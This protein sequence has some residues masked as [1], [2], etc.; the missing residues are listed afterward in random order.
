MKW[1]KVPSKFFLPL[2]ML[3]AVGL[4]S[5]SDA[6]RKHR[7]QTEE[8]S[9][10]IERQTERLRRIM[11]PLLKV[12]NQRMSLDDVR[13]TILDD[14]AINA[15]AGGGGRYFVT[16]GLLR[17]A[18]DDRLRGVLAHEIAHQDLHH[19]TKAQ[20]VGV[21]IGIGA[22]I[23]EQIFP[24]AATVAPLAGAVIGSSYTRPM[25][26]EA[27]RHAV[28]LLRRAGYSEHVMIDT[29]DWLLRQQ[30]DTGGGVMATHP[31]TSERIKAL[32]ALR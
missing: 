8:N 26:L 22:A 12:T 14:A 4:T 23:L 31:A 16:T 6:S 3:L 7:Y 21:G 28:T 32:Q 18:N 17:Q 24:S 2:A 5:P 15:G 9:N 13:I 19:P 1:T 20:V 29:L 30:G 11:I 10:Q 27:D 25:E